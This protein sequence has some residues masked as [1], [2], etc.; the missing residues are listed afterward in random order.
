VPLRIDITK[1]QGQP[2]PVRSPVIIN[3]DG[4]VIGRAMD[5]AIVLHDETVSRRHARISF[6]D[7]RYYLIDQSSN[8]TLIYNRDLLVHGEKVELLNGDVLVIGDHELRVHVTETGSPVPVSEKYP[9]VA[10]LRG[11]SVPESS[12]EEKIGEYPYAKARSAEQYKGPASPVKDLSI[13][14]FF[15][16]TGEE[17]VPKSL[18][19]EPSRGGSPGG[20]QPA[21]KK[22]NAESSSK[23]RGTDAVLPDLDELFKDMDDFHP[24]VAAGGSSEGASGG[25]AKVD[26]VSSSL[27]PP[28]TES[29]HADREEKPASETPKISEQIRQA[30]EEVYSELFGRFLKG[31]GFETSSFTNTEIPDLMESLGAVFRELV[32]GLWTVLKGRAELKAEIRVAMTMVRPTSNNPLKFSPTLDDAVKHL[33]KRDHPSFLEPIEAVR[34]GFDDIMNHQLA[35][36]A[37]IQASLVDALNQFDPQRLSEKNKDSSILHTKGKFWQAYCEAYPELKEK[38]LEGIFGK[39][40]LRTY[41]EQLERLRIKKARS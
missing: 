32:N 14:D 10:P 35:L 16:D 8:G 37:G 12:G 11:D 41:Q 26:E 15:K 23:G 27:Y 19:A 21:F 1:C 17:D 39:V 13:T 25:E 33:L 6:E 3:Q 40:F 34:E 24:A 30:P 20:V 22:E 4:G 36:H 28:E 9:C 31:A 7:G 2:A 38:A 5:N 18:K 29:P